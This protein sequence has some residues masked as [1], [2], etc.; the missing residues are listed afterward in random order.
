MVCVVKSEVLCVCQ[1]LSV[2]NDNGKVLLPFVA[3]EFH[4]GRGNRSPA[5]VLNVLRLTA[6]K[7]KK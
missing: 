7:T 4:Q 5:I 1:F 3:F 6:T 2:R